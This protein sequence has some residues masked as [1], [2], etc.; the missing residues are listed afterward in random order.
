MLGVQ[1]IA[2]VVA[3]MKTVPELAGLQV[4]IVI[5]GQWAPCKVVY[6]CYMG[7]RV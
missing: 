1:T 5:N 2:R 6:R 3:S 7:F 4:E